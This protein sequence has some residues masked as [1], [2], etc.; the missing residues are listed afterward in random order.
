MTTMLNETLQTIESLRSIHGD[1]SDRQVA[2]GDLEQI[3]NASVRAASASAM[4]SYSVVVVRDKEAQQALCGYH[5]SCVLA[6]FVDYTRTIAT[7]GRRGLDFAPAD[8]EWFVTGS[9]SAALAA[10][11][12]VIAAKSLGIDSLVTNG[13]HRGRMERLWEMLGLPRRYCFPLLALVLGYPASEPPHRK[14]RLAGP[15]IVH[16]ETYHF[17]TAE[18]TDGIVEQYDD[19]SQ[20]MGLVEDWDKGGHEHYLD[21]FHQEWLARARRKGRTQM[22]R[23]LRLA[24]F[25]EQEGV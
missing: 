13:L 17:L 8:M 7:A 16:H 21:W 22:F 11:T 18:E 20:H 9:T 12:A 15:G 10:Q 14:G 3:L 24:G 2:D 5:G 4:Q 23:R 25:L 1:F 19:K 6:Y